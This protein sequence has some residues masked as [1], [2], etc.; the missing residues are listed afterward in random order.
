MIPQEVYDQVAAELANNDIRNGLWTRAYAEADGQDS[1]ARAIYIK[2]RVAQL[3]GS[4]GRVATSAPK[5]GDGVLSHFGRVAYLL[6]CLGIAILLALC[7]AAAGSRDGGTAVTL[8]SCFAIVP[9]I[10]RL[11]DTGDSRLWCLVM[12]IPG[13]SFVLHL[14]LLFAPRGYALKSRKTQPPIPV[15]TSA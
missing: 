10:F 6:S 4:D 7:Y 5:S 8:L 11:R 3:T 12:F 15:P 14:Y 2:L 9:S 13:F 1:K